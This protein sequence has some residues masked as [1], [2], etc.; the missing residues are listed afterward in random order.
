A[1]TSFLLSPHHLIAR[2]QRR[3]ACRCLRASQYRPVPA[4]TK[5]AVSR[6]E[7]RL[8]WSNNQPQAAMP[9]MGMTYPNGRTK[10][11][12]LPYL[13]RNLGMAAQEIAYINSRVSTVAA[14]SQMNV[15]NTA[16]RKDSTP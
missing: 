4:I 6:K 8:T 11:S 7:S 16:S 12:L 1:V 2:A 3:G 10:R 5:A 13:G 15:P 14:A 9:R